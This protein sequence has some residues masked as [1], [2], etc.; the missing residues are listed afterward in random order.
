MSCRLSL[1]GPPALLDGEGRPVPIPAKAFPLVVYLTLAGSSTPAARSSIR[2]FLWGSAEAKTAAANLRKFLSRVRV[3]QQEFGFELIHEDRNHVRLA[4]TLET[5]L[6]R[7]LKIVSTQDPAAVLAL[8]DIYRGDLLEGVLLE[9]P[10]AREWLQVQRTRL[11]DIFIGAVAPQLEA[12]TPGAGGMMFRV[13]ARRLVEVDPYNET[14]HRALMRLF[15]AEREPARV[16]EV[17]FNLQKR[18]RD[19]LGVE[20]DV[21]TTELYRALVPMKTQAVQAPNGEIGPARAAVT[22]SPSEES[23]EASAQSSADDGARTGAPKVTVLPPPPTP[24]LNYHHHMAVS[25]VEDVA[26]GLCRFRGLTSVAP[27]TSAEF[28]LGGKKALMETF[29][30]DYA[31]ETQLQDRGGEAWLSVKL[32]NARTRKILWADQYEFNRD[33]IARQYRELSLRIILLLVDRIERTELSRYE[34]EPNKTAYHLFLAGQRHLRT[35]GLPSVRRA[36]RHFKAAMSACPDFVPAISG[37][38]RTYQQEWLLMARGD[39]DLLAET[40]KLATLSCEIDPDDAR[41]YRELGVCRLYNGRFDESIA[42]LAQAEKRSPQFADLLN[43]FADAYSHT[44]DFPAALQKINKAIELNPLCPDHYWWTAAGANY[45]LQQYREAIRCMSHMRDQS[46]AYRLMAA[47]YAM[48]GD[49]EHARMFVKKTKDIHPDF[50]ISGWLSI[51]PIQ[52][53]HYA[54]HYEQGLREAGFS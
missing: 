12:S 17:Y 34:A 41:G 21:T 45:H 27:H 19:D 52:D 39:H 44:C 30:I 23:S 29:G 53:P 6:A 15:A 43:D 38:A 8:C 35:L 36:R 37:L 4:N 32:V 25:L 51:V 33:T 7:F 42:A 10:E 9:E 50:T 31:V 11:R 48:L 47:C 3:R 1:F 24:E 20:P 22:V 14:G 28:S 49:R 5:D 26:I 13:A 2:H 40:E 18:L 16:R 54:R 46:A